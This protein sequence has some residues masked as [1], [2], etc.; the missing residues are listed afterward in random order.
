MLLYGKTQGAYDWALTRPGN[1]ERE[2]VDATTQYPEFTP[3]WPGVYT[4]TVTDEA[5]GEPGDLQIYAGTWRGVIVGQDAD[6][7]PVADPSCTGCHAEPRRGPVHALA[8][9]PATPRSSPTT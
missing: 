3:D 9:R 2:L 4:V 5:T 6:G 7:R 1:V 8:R